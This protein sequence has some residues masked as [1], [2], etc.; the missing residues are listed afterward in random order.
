MKSVLITDGEQRAALAAARSL[1]SAGYRVHVCAS[2]TP[3]I[4]GTSRYCATEIKVPDPLSD[5]SGFVAKAARI[6]ASLDVDV[7]LPISEAS[8]LAVL[9][10]RERFHCAIPFVSAKIFEQ[11]CDKRQVLEIA[12]ARGI[13]VPRQTELCASADFHDAVSRLHY[14]VVVKPSRSVSG[15][16][17][18]R[19]R[20]KISY[21]HDEADLSASL[22]QLPSAAYPVLLQERIV[23]PG[24]GVSLLIWNGELRASFAHRRIREKPP[25][26]GVSVLRESI[27]L[28]ETLLSRS[29]DLLAALEWQGVAMIEY[30]LDGAT[31]VPYL[32]EINGR[33][34]GSLQLAIDSGVDFPVLLVQAALGVLSAPVTNYR[35][36][37][38]SRWEWG[39]VDNLLAMLFHSPNRLALPSG[40]P[41]R[42]GALRDFIR[43]CSSE[44]RAEVLRL[45][46][47]LPFLRESVDWI[48][49]K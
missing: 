10:T 38:R 15:P 21:S 8:L 45:N 22:Q 29:V 43:S 12:R 5:P 35:E 7:L 9:P 24:V 36:G 39:D 25:S 26:G 40:R 46:D 27:P 1:G 20:N 16:E 13:S 30:K 32:M 47:P 28:D 19:I 37:V 48:R 3:C 34:W 17:L 18:H 44:T 11:I 31:G 41:N 42:L 49:G 2:S 23:G 4:A 6:A 33:L 14:P